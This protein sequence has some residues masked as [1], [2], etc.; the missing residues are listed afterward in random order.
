MLS[1]GKEKHVT[2][3]QNFLEEFPILYYIL[4]RSYKIVSILMFFIFWK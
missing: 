1:E 4:D 3:G 2:H